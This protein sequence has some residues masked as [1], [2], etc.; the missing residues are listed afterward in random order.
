MASHSGLCLSVALYLVA[1]M[2]PG[3]VNLAGAC[4]LSYQSNMITRVRRGSRQ[5]EYKLVYR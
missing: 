5:L 2:I 1:E 4:S 3:T